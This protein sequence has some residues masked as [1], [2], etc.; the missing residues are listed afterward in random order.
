MVNNAEE[1]SSCPKNG[2]C[3][4]ELIPNKSLNFIE[5]SIGAL[6]LKA[7]ESENIIFKYRFVRNQIENTVDG[8]YS[9]EIYFEFN[10]NVSELILENT[11][12][13]QAKLQLN[14]ICYCKGTAK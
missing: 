3:T 12:L 7:V 5:D 10:P 13:K 11:E 2:K 8:H 4:S 6:Y 9:E 14:R 1:K